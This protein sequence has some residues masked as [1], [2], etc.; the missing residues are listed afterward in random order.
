M[1]LFLIILA[2]ATILGG[3]AGAE[4]FNTSFSIIGAVIGGV[5]T[6]AILLGLGAYFDSQA[7]KS[8]DLSPEVRAIFDRMITGKS[9]PTPQDIRKA[10]Q[11]FHNTPKANDT[12][13]AGTEYL[14]ATM[15]GLVKQDAESIAR[16]EI[17]ERRLIP[18]HAIKRDIIINAYSKDFQV[19]KKHLAEMDWSVDAKNRQLAEI[20][21]DFN[22]K[23]ESIK[24]LSW[25]ELDKIIALMKK[26]RTDLNEIE[27]SI[28]SQDASYHIVAPICS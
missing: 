22:K 2:A 11:T 27:E 14:F 12:V 20:Q 25:Q 5:G 28:R 1:K 13:K 10:K 18:H 8:S 19:A 4:I 17:P 23:I 15:Q 16:G 3:F 21:E 7:K 6:A 26:T 24:G 9:N